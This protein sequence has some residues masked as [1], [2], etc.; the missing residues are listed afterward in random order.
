MI[1]P[2][3]VDEAVEILR[4]RIPRAWIDTCLATSDGAATLLAVVDFFVELDDRDAERF[5][6]LFVAPFS[7]Q[8]DLPASGA[9]VA[10]TT[11]A[12]VRRRSGAL[13]TLPVGTRVQTH[14]GHVFQTIAPLSFAGGE[15]DAEK[16]VDAISVVPGNFAV[17]PPS[18]IT[19]FTPIAKGLTGAG[20]EI[21]NF[22][23]PGG[24]SL[25]LTTDATKPHP[26]RASTVGLPVE[27]LTATGALAPNV[28][29]QAQI[30]RVT[31]GDSY[32][33]GPGTE[34]AYAWT[35]VSDQTYPTLTMGTAPYIWAVR[36]WNEVGF[37][38]RNVT[39][40][41]GGR[42]GTLDAL[43][44][45]RGR[46]RRPGEGDESVR[47]RLRRRPLSPSA[48]GILEQVVLAI[49]P[50]GFGRHDVRIY[51]LGIVPVGDASPLAE[52]YQPAG[53]TIAGIHVARMR[54]PHTPDTMARHKRDHT[55]LGTFVNS[56]FVG[57]AGVTPWTVVVR[58]TLPVGFDEPTA[59]LI[60]LAAWEAITAARQRGCFASLYEPLQ[61][62]YPP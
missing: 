58:V 60:R 45:A 34:T 59:R 41:T 8:V 57:V 62:G 24:Y 17:I 46:P 2:L 51:E 18:E 61:W 50:Y 4:S 26:W 53:G 36:D 27:I 49:A 9:R 7:G 35:P 5:S 33:T 16:T 19:E 56:G 6:G 39:R 55:T 37:E 44:E 21:W 48:L 14:D 40:V 42:D 28:G 47:T 11:L 15:L 29:A 23:V 54:T 1:A 13:L 25:R 31:V 43:A 12:I 10:E 3:T 38:V 22:S 52:N 20:T 32:F 30:E